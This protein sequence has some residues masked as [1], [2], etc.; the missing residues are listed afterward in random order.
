MNKNKKTCKSTKVYKLNQ[1]IHN[2]KNKS[3]NNNGM[4][5]K[6]NNQNFNI[7]VMPPQI[8]DNDITALFN[9]IITIVK[10][11]IELEKKAEILNANI[12][13]EKTLKELQEKQAECIRLKN[14]IIYLKKKLKEN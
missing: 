9:G 14:E 1:T 11:K 12:T 4:D 7:H 6:I 3:A 10:K 8:T 2:K 5:K 13:I